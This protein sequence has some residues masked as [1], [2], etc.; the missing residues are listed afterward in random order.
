LGINF[1]NSSQ[2]AAFKE[3]GLKD[4]AARWGQEFMPKDM[5]DHVIRNF[6]KS[7]SQLQQDLVAEY[8]SQKSANNSRYFVEFGATDGLKLSNSFSLEQ[9]GWTGLLVEPNE[10]WHE[11]L[12]LNRRVT[13]DHRCVYS[14]SNIKIEF[15]N[16]EFGELSGIEK[17]ADQDGWS[18]T[19]RKGSISQVETVTLEDLLRYHN[20]PSRINY[21]S[22]DTEGSEFEIMKVFNFEL[23]SFD[24]I[25]VEHNFGENEK[26]MQDLLEENGYFRILPITSAW[27]GWYLNCDLQNE[28]FNSN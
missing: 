22:V 3:S 14:S 25:S 8:I 4:I 27:D 15:I 7:Y 26:H 9:H 28:W 11:E 16:S 12:L 20:A 19:R 24:F 17:H 18:N 5:N 23:W 2:N 13:I 6:Q 21:L 10:I 1:L